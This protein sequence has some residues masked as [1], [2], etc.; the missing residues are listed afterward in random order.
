[1]RLGGFFIA[2]L[3]R[4]WWVWAVTVMVGVVPL[5][6]SGCYRS[7]CVIES[8]SIKG[9]LDSG[10]AW[11]VNL[12]SG[13]W[14]VGFRWARVNLASVDAST[15]RYFESESDV[16]VRQDWGP[17][18]ARDG[19]HIL[20]WRTSGGSGSGWRTLNVDVGYPTLI[21]VSGAIVLWRFR[22]WRQRSSL[23]PAE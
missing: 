2:V 18:D 8:V 16:S 5:L 4:A 14:N 11:Q 21:V 17:F 15:K 6:M 1:M 19:P 22:K 20:R 12:L 7:L 10:M 3:R 9:V 23:G 13:E